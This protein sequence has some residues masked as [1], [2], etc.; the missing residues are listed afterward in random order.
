MDS[1]VRYQHYQEIQ[2]PGN[3]HKENVMLFVPW[4]YKLK[5]LIGEKFD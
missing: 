1:I 4:R 2:D 5:E 3:Y